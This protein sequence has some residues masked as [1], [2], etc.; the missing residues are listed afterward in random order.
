MIKR[1]SRTGPATGLLVQVLLLGLLAET[2][3]LGAIG[4]IAGMLCALTMAAVLARALGP[5]ERLGPASWVTLVRATLAATP[6][7]PRRCSRSA[8]GRGNRS[9]A[10]SRRP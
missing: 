10:G 5:G 4:W 9:R 1:A 3:G 8:G 7:T 6:L 2:D